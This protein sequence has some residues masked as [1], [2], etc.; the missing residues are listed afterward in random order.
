MSSTATVTEGMIQSS[1][2]LPVGD[3]DFSG[4]GTYFV[5]EAKR[6]GTVK[7]THTFKLPGRPAGSQIVVDFVVEEFPASWFAPLIVL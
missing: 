7:R 5:S 3:D 1:T 6:W 2:S 4:G